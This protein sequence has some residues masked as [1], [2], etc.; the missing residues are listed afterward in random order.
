MLKSG[1]GLHGRNEVPKILVAD[2]SPTA[3]KVTSAVLSKNG[4]QIIQVMDGEQAVLETLRQKPHAVVVDLKMPKKDGFQ[5]CMEL[6]KEK[7]IYFPILLLTAREDIESMVQGLEAGADDYLIKPFIEMEFVA[8]IK[9]LLRLKRL[10]DALMH[11]NRKL[12]YLSSHDE[13]TNLYNH[14]YFISALDKLVNN[15]RREKNNLCL[16]IFDIDHF[17]SVN[18]TYGHLE[19]D[20]VLKIIAQHLSDSFTSDTLLSRYGGEEFT[21]LFPN[22]PIDF[23]VNACQKVI[24]DCKQIL[25]QHNQLNYHITMSAGV[26]TTDYLESYNPNELIQSA[27]KLLYHSKN[28]GRNKLTFCGSKEVKDL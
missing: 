18:D 26:S 7:H 3:L 15:A 23:V 16:A 24:D 20:K 13:L 2:D 14:R 28:S 1:L 21:A 8:R 10:N 27:D 6:K 11:A 5:V 9:V 19:G 25:F 4:Y 12:K 22:R 17:K